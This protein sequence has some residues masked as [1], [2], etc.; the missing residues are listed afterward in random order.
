M[1]KSEPWTGIGLGVY[2]Y[3][4]PNYKNKSIS[5]N[6]AVSSSNVLHPES[7]WLDLT[8]QAGILSMVF[9]LFLILSILPKAFIFQK[10]QI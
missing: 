9:A 7:N 1:I 10:Q 8:S 3:I 6:S 4:F 5:F 2:E